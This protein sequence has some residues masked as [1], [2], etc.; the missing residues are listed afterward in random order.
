MGFF[1]MYRATPTA[2]TSGKLARVLLDEFGRVQVSV[3]GLVANYDTVGYESL[4]VS[5]TAVGF[6]SIPATAVRAF[7]TIEDADIRFRVDDPLPTTIEGHVLVA[8]DILL[9]ESAADIASFKAIR[10]GAVD[11]ILKVTYQL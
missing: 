2:L 3:T 11:A 1:G 4:I 10:D 9:L 5:D 7:I 6:A 8:T